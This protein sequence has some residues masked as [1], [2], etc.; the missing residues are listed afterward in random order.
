MRTTAMECSSSSCTLV[1]VSSPPLCLRTCGL[2]IF[3]LLLGSAQ[4]KECG[5][6]LPGMRCCLFCLPNKHSLDAVFLFCHITQHPS[7]CLQQVPAQKMYISL[8]P[9]PAPAVSSGRQNRMSNLSKRLQQYGPV[10]IDPPHMTN[11]L[12]Q[13]VLRATAAESS[14]HPS[15]PVRLR[16]PQASRKSRTVPLRCCT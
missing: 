8:S 4:P 13:E 9:L 7:F 14:K 1:A 12:S 2:L 3:A 5:P 6:L 16:L 11:D 15:S 10:P